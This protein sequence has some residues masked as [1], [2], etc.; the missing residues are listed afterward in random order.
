[1]NLR[2]SPTTFGEVSMQSAASSD[3][4]LQHTE[5]SLGHLILRSPHGGR[6]IVY[7]SYGVMFTGRSVRPTISMLS[8]LGSF[9]Q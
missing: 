7:A 8:R 9:I 5:P 1:M 2:H 3:L 6:Q 4:S